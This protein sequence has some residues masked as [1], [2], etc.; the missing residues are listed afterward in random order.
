MI[1]D[2][3]GEGLASPKAGW[4]EWW[5]RQGDGI[6]TNHSLFIIQS[7]KIMLRVEKYRSTYQK[8]IATRCGKWYQKQEI[9]GS[10]IYK[11]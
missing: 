1:L 6:S 3:L 9:A 11:P 8:K 5:V 10:A 2:H 4:K 7:Q